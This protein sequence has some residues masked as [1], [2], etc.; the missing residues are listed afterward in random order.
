[1]VAARYPDDLN[2]YHWKNPINLPW[3]RIKTFDVSR[4][5]ESFDDTPRRLLDLEA[6]K[7]VKMMC[8]AIKRR[9][10]WIKMSV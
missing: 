5:L 8:M 4:L 3:V 6:K 7:C 10:C 9:N 1:V 2:G